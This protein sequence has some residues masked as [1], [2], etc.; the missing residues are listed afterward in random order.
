MHVGVRH[1]AIFDLNLTRLLSDLASP[2]GLVAIPTIIART[3]AKV[4]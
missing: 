1:C 3:L 2:R 4:A